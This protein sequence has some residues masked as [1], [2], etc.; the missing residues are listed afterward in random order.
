MPG[1]YHRYVSTVHIIKLNNKH[2]IKYKIKGIAWALASKCAVTH[3]VSGL[4]FPLLFGTSFST[5]QVAATI[6]KQFR[7]ASMQ[8]TKLHPRS[9]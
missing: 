3:R 6:H 2:I 8:N 1:Q 5:Y 9:T 7:K 4:Y